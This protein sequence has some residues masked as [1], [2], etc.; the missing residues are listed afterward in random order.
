MQD[1]HVMA[2][3]SYQDYE[4][5]FQVACRRAR[6]NSERASPDGARQRYSMRSAGQPHAIPVLQEGNLRFSGTLSD[7]LISPQPSKFPHP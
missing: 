2:V 1:E 5:C 7:R 6:R 4:R 3:E